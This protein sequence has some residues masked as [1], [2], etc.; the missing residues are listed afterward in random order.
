MEGNN[1]QKYMVYIKMLQHSYIPI[2]RKHYNDFVFNIDCCNY[3][4]KPLSC[5]AKY[6]CMTSYDK[7]CI[8]YCAFLCVNRKS[9]V[10]LPDSLIN[11][12]IWNLGNGEKNYRKE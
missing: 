9:C 6:S 3:G 10:H 2:T 1:Y 7:W 12:L 11:I 8:C 4:K 5:I